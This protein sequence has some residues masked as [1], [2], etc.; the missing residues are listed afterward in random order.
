MIVRTGYSTKPIYGYV[1]YQIKAVSITDIKRYISQAPNK[2]CPDMDPLTTKLIKANIDIV[3]P[4]LKTIVNKP[5]T[6]GTVCYAYK[7]DVV[8]LITKR[9]IQSHK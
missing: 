5:I 7:E 1:F 8:S 3:Y 2:N 4:I 6:S 9:Q